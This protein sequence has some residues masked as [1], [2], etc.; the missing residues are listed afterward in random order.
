[1]PPIKQSKI[2]SDNFQSIPLQNLS[3]RRSLGHSESNAS[4][5]DSGKPKFNEE[6]S[7]NF[8]SNRTSML[9]SFAS[10]PR[11]PLS[12]NSSYTSGPLSPNFTPAITP[13]ITRSP[14]VS[15]L[16][17]SN[18]ASPIDSKAGSVLDMAERSHKPKRGSR[19]SDRVTLSD[20]SSEQEYRV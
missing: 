2:E 10:L 16:E 3:K 11:S 14:S 19:R 20:R 7:T 12:A 4:R 8:I 6:V 13:L 1:M 18:I 17:T 15:P 9:S 5:S